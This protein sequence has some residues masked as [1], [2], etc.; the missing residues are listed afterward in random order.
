MGLYK[1]DRIVAELTGGGDDDASAADR[2]APDLARAEVLLSV[3][4]APDGL[5]DY[6]RAR[7]EALGAD[8]LAVTIDNRDVQDAEPIFDDVFDVP[9][10]VERF[11]AVFDERVAGRVPE[12]AAIVVEA[13][14]SEPPAVRQ[15]VAEEARVR[16]IE[17]GA[18]P[19]GTRVQILS[20]FKQGFSWLRES[21]GPRLEGREIGEIVVEFLRNEPPEE[22]PQQA[23][24]TPLRW[25]HEIFPIDEVL[26]R[27]PGACARSHSV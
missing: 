4:K 23:I 1:L 15:R 2:A 18:D 16:L 3:E 5:G 8:E 11:W 26:A 24:H 21:V 19:E 22:W 14:L 10:E 12:G 25:L 6:V 7:A 27:R 13:R 20:A 9:S 17:A